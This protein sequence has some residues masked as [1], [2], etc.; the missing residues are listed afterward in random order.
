VPKRIPAVSNE[1]ILLYGTGLD[2]LV[3]L[4]PSQVILLTGLSEDQLRDRKRMRPPLPPFPSQRKPGASVWYSIGSIREYLG[5]LTK[6]QKFNKE[7]G[8]RRGD[9][10]AYPTFVDWLNTGKISDLWPMAI[11]GRQERPVD[12]WATV[13]GDVKMAR[14]DTCE[15]MTLGNYLS[16][17]MR[18]SK[19]A[20]S[21]RLI[22]KAG[23]WNKGDLKRLSTRKPRKRP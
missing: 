5:W 21:N 4:L 2:D 17:M 23:P 10:A 12:F 6:E 14:S 18:I 8:R 7:I 1:M 11:V 20:D 15:W 22:R 3:P 19:A 13:R 9:F 16:R